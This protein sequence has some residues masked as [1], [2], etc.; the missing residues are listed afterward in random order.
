[1]AESGQQG[2]KPLRRLS[3][4]MLVIALGVFLGLGADAAWDAHQESLREIDYLRQLHGDLLTTQRDLESAI[5]AQEMVRRSG[6]L[7]I[8]GINAR[9]LPT[10]DSLAQWTWRASFKPGFEPMLGTVASLITTGDLRLIQ[11]D[12]LRREVLAYEQRAQQFQLVWL[13]LVQ[14]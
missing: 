1:M 2:R 14:E 12:G 4:E 7:A 13:Q 11:D 6:D 3:A 10:P 5:T 9:V 8:A